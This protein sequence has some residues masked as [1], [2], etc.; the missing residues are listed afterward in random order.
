MY[1]V[2]TILTHFSVSAKKCF[3]ENSYQKDGKSK[4]IVARAGGPSDRCGRDQLL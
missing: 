2:R 3:A 4:G 1:L